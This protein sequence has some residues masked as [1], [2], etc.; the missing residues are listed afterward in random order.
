MFPEY[1]SRDSNTEF[2]VSF[3]E[4]FIDCLRM[5]NY[6]TVFVSPIFQFTKDTYCIDFEIEQEI[7]MTTK[8][9]RVTVYDYYETSE[10]REVV[11]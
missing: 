10:Y 1:P 9:A 7:V 5:N 6:C 8:P 2:R 3:Q 11:F 4:G